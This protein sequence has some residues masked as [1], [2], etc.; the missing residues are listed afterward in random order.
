[1]KIPLIVTTQLPSCSSL[2]SLEVDF[3]FA[4]KSAPNESSI[5]DLT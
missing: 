5:A 2:N 1:M 4:I 3:K